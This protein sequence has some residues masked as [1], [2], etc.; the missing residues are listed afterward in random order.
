MFMDHLCSIRKF[1]IIIDIIII[2][3][4][5]LMQPF[6]AA[7]AASDHIGLQ[8]GVME[9][10]LRT[11]KWSVNDIIWGTMHECEGYNRY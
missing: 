6:W 9:F 3:T 5:R 4:I 11:D 7:Y 1:I 2:T 8:R 10:F